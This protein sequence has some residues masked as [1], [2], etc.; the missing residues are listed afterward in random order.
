MLS[1]WCVR[2]PSFPKLKGHVLVFCYLL[3]VVF[4]CFVLLFVMLLY[5]SRRLWWDTFSQTDIR[6]N[7]SNSSLTSRG[8]SWLTWT[9][10]SRCRRRDFVLRRLC[11]CRRGT[12]PALAVL[13]IF[14]HVLHPSFSTEAERTA[15]APSKRTTSSYLF[16]NISAHPRSLQVSFFFSFPND[17]HGIVWEKDSIRFSRWLRIS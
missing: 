15:R 7:A 1:S 2:F 11:L 9:M 14:I 4:Y 5:F 16:V 8:G 13:F 3:A 12:N 17:N 10:T 6:T